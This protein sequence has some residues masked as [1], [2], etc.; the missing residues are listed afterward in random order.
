VNATTEIPPHLIGELAAKLLGEPNTR[1]STKGD[2]RFG[3]HGSLSVNVKMGTWYDHEAQ[4]G[5]GILDFIERQT[6][7]KDGERWERL[8]ELTGFKP[9]PKA[10]G[11][12]SPRTGKDKAASGKAAIVATYDYTDAAGALRYQVC[13]L[14]PKDFRQRRP[15]PDK[16]GEWLWN[17][18]GVEPLP[19]R[20]PQ[21]LKAI[22]RGDTVVIVEGEKDADNLAKIGIETSCNH[23]GAKKWRPELTP[24][25]KDADVVLIG[26]NDQAGRDHVDVVG[27]EL[28]GTAK[29][30][31]HLD[32][33]RVW[34]ECPAK[35]DVSDWI[36]AGATF[37]AILAAIEDALAWEAPKEPTES[38]P[39]A[40][41]GNFLLVR[42][43][44]GKFKP[45]VYYIDPDDD[46][47]EPKWICS[48]LE[49]LADTRDRDNRNWGTLFEVVD[50]DGKSHVWSM[51][52]EI[53]PT[54][55][56]GTD[57][58]RVLANR[59]LKIAAGGKA[60]TRL[61][62]YVT[63]WE[64]R[65]KVR[66]V[67]A[68]GWCGDAFVMPDEAFG[69]S[70]NVVVQ[71]EGVAPEFE[72]RGSLAGWRQDIAARCVG[73]SRLVLGVSAAFAGPLLKLVG[74]ESGGVH[75][76]GPSSIG[77][78]SALHVARSVW[79][80]PL[81]SW[82][83]TDN[84][85]E[86]V[87]S[88][89]CD[90]LLTL[91]EISQAHPRVVGEIAYMLG[92]ERGKGRMRRNATARAVNRWRVLFLSTGEVGLAARLAEGGEKAR[93]G[94]EVRVLEFAADAGCG[95]GVFENLHGFTNGSWLAEHLRH[96]PEKNCGH[97]AR[98]FLRH[99]TKDAAGL[100]G[101]IAELRAGFIAE[102]CPEGA[103]G[104]VRRACG[105]FAIIGIAGELATQCGITGWQQGEAKA[106][107][108]R[109]WQN[110][111]T[112]RG[113]SGAAETREAFLQV[114]LFLEQHGESR[115]SLAWDRENERPVINRAGFRKVSDEG[116][117]YYVLPEVW[118]REVC[119][120]LD[121]S[122]VASAM[123]ERGWLDREGKHMTCKP[124]IPGEGHQR[125]YVIRPAFLS[126]DT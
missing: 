105:R 12:T 69:G 71:T 75:L 39:T 26:D 62:D 46:D 30:I 112:A 124:R 82:R 2:M 91:D 40:R 100:A 50:K 103:D 45:G 58:R 21:V 78:T 7:A 68:V 111:L 85:A 90:A 43:E 44:T 118:H 56:D 29:S 20:L 28:A 37:E 70:E 89:A 87:A 77:K 64:P 114:R 60:R 23:G 4:A 59:G 15:K 106:A 117:T 31:R 99:I 3:S 88:G 67:A 55:G 38:D 18:Q 116:A 110:W 34:P 19:Y 123:A 51:P 72:V 122:A 53:G 115:F 74:E 73:N 94:Q 27:A 63:I 42:Q 32:I 102:N 101:T 81:G 49:P 61:S 9:E 104:Q 79:G 98:E 10:N 66:C 97:P 76:R 65:R 92:N 126:A 95:H 17:M 86:A 47:G 14:E 24:H 13:R 108:V 41:Q 36:K 48:R 22:V 109:C 80:T 107:A 11:K 16:P 6:G 52:A 54:V 120:G 5:G 35:G 96:A 113:G 57:F 33:A 119:K 8:T 125:V 121:A 25:F 84:N 83:T 1:R 93:A